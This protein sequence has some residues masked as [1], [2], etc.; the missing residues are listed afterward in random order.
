MRKS[1]DIRR[2]PARKTEKVAPA[3]T[4]GGDKVVAVMMPTLAAPRNA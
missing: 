4:I 3:A 1:S 2:R